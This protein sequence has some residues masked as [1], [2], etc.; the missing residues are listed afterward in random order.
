MK[1]PGDFQDYN[2]GCFTLN[3]AKALQ[4]AIASEAG[5]HTELN[6]VDDCY[7]VL[8]F[9]VTQFEYNRLK[10]IEGFFLEFS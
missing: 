2:S 8:A 6:E 9:D 3:K 1:D 7:E 4:R 10:R 5:V